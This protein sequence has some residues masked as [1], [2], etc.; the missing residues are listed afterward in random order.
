MKLLLLASLI[1]MPALAAEY[2][3]TF[4]R[5]AR[6]IVK[7]HCTHCHGEEEIPEGGADPRPRP[8]RTWQSW[9]RAW[10]GAGGDSFKAVGFDAAVLS[11]RRIRSAHEDWLTFRASS[12]R[13]TSAMTAMVPHARVPGRPLNHP[14]HGRRAPPR[15][16]SRQPS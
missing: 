12:H 5:D 7:A 4:E 8:T 15:L 6:P 9:W 13:M 10:R 16:P 2:A 11:M 1:P 14:R 3:L